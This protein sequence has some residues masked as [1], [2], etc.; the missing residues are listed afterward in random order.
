MESAS[1]LRQSLRAA[2]QAVPRRGTPE[3]TRERLAAAA[4]RLFN[5]AGHHGTDS[6]RIAK[7][8][9]YSTG[10]FYKHF[11]D[12]WGAFLAAYK[13]WV[14]K[15]WD[16]VPHESA[17]ERSTALMARKLVRIGIDFHTRW[18]GLR[19]SLAEL[20][21]SDP[22][23]CQFY[24]AQR[25]RQL[26]LMVTLRAQAGNPPRRREVDAIHLF[27]IERTL[28]AIA[29]GEIQALKLDRAFVIQDLTQRVEAVLT[30]PAA[31]VDRL[32]VRRVSKPE[33]VAV[34]L[35]QWKRV[36]IEMP[37]HAG[38]RDRNRGS[39]GRR[40]GGPRVPRVLGCALATQ[41]H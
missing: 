10:T 20:I 14:S 33:Q 5:E 32:V 41:R 15:E 16:A 19:A 8:A 18:R 21:V 38:R 31:C 37:G 29:R 4:A 30:W 17:G 34:T 39:G 24:N 12:K 1:A 23:V 27:M 25:R 22:Q 3:A 2:P 7:A 6:N 9:G 36:D 11:K 26:D 28:D 35:A 40:I 13:I